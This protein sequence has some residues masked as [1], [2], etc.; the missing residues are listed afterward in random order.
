MRFVEDDDFSSP[1]QLLAKSVS[2]QDP[3]TGQERYFESSRKLSNSGQ[4]RMALT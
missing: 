1:L 3:L 4:S 2:F